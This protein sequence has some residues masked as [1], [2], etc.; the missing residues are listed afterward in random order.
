MGDFRRLEVW[1]AAHKL[2]CD[3]YRFTSKF[4]KTEIYGLSSQLRRAASS[5]PAN[6]AEGC[7][8]NADTEFG[9]Y[10]WISLGSANELEYHLLLSRDVGLLEESAF[11]GLCADVKAVRAMLARLQNAVNRSLPARR[12]RA[13]P[14]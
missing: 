4:P 5:I 11:N 14:R 2:A 7:G 3:V 10:I 13:T 12:R 9:R 8:R 6:L 1:K